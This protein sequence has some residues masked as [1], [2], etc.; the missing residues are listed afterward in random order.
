MTG[1][2]PKPSSR[3]PRTTIKRQRTNRPGAIVGAIGALFVVY[4]FDWAVA[5][6][7]SAA[8]LGLDTGS[9]RHGV[10][11]RGNGSSYGVGQSEE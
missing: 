10:A 9:D 3:P 1:S 4:V 7:A 11:S 8:F 5:V 2:S 6:D